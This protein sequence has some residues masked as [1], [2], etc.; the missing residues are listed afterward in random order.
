M[1]NKTG[2]GALV[3]LAA[4]AIWTGGAGSGGASAVGARSLPAVSAPASL[5][6]SQPELIEGVDIEALLRRMTVEQK[7]GQL[8][9]VDIL[10]REMNP[11]IAELVADRHV[12]GVA[13]FGYNIRNRKQVQQLLA[14]I[15]QLDLAG[16]PPFISIDQEGGTVVRLKESAAV[17]PSAMA[18]GATRSS[19]LARLTGKVVGADLRSLGFTM[20]LAP[21]L[22]VNSSPQNPVIGVRS[23]GENA[24][25]V[26]EL[27]S[28]YVEGLQSAGVVAVAKHFP[29]HGDT[30][31]DSHFGLPSLPHE[32][33][34]LRRVEFVPF[35]R[36]IGDGLQALM[37]AHI[38][39]PRVAEEPGLPATLSRRILTD[40]LRQELG[41]EGIVI[42]DGL[43]MRG[44]VE[45]FGL[46]AAAVR[47]IQAG[48]DMVLVVWTAER[49][50]EAR[51][52][53]L[54][55]VAAGQISP[56]RLDTSV[57]RILRV[58]ARHR[59]LSGQRAPRVEVTDQERRVTDRVAAAALTLVR[60]RDQVLPLHSERPHG[61]LIASQ[62][63]AFSTA[64][65]RLLGPRAGEKIGLHRAP[66]SKRVALDIERVLNAAAGSEVVVIGVSSGHYAPLIQRLKS[67]Q[68]RLPVVVVS[69]GS[70]YLLSEFPDVEGYLCTYSALPASLQ[71]AAAAL[72][73][74]VEPQ[75]R[76]PVSLPGLHPYGY[77][78]RYSA[79]APAPGSATPAG[80]AQSQQARA[81][82]VARP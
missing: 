76:L 62:H 11:K 16:I 39:L 61:I 7:V 8:L 48:A 4:L 59:I 68:P 24:E 75:G 29:G 44:I 34:R 37:T 1:T 36:C 9:F 49:K 51:R 66:N 72:V 41:F 58:K 31:A 65:A 32:I 26:A 14:S 42:T 57:R 67:E 2:L 45:K 12:G 82:D 77:G 46:G 38:A 47:A 73:G 60:N 50:E 17:L 80:S 13:L 43:E 23:F 6:A 53:L 52:A 21:V 15:Y 3:A 78:L 33:G 27:G 63:A 30:T 5:P 54:D 64:L 20:N 10:G 18:L 69:F 74:T 81:I 35:V 25:L 19:E 55:A 79:L 40:T 28:A 70:P 56:E 22:D 71:V